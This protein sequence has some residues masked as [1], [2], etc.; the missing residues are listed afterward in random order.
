M[1]QVEVLSGTPVD[2]DNCHHMLPY[3]AEMTV[4]KCVDNGRFQNECVGFLFV[5]VYTVGKNDIKNLKKN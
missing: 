1:E 2:M 3:I 4:G 5:I